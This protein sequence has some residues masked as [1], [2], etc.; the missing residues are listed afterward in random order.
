MIKIYQQR[1]NDKVFLKAI[2]R[3]WFNLHKYVNAKYNE[4]DDVFPDEANGLSIV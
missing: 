4:D 1:S 2:K 3:H